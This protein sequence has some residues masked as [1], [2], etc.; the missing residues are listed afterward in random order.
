MFAEFTGRRRFA[1]PLNT[2]L[3][4]YE[5][6]DSSAEGDDGD[7]RTYERLVQVLNDVVIDRGVASFLCN[8]DVY[9]GSHL[10]TTVQGDGS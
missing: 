3:T 5:H 9:V 4:T 6:T 10:V 2:P 8:L 7:I 1:H